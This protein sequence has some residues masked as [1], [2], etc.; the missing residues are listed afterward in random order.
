MEKF[1]LYIRENY[2]SLLGALSI[3]LLIWLA[4]NGGKEYSHVIEVPLN[5]DNM[6]KNIVFER[7]P[8]EKITVRVRA[9][10]RALFG[11]NFIDQKIGLELPHIVKDQTIILDEIKDRINFPAALGIEVEDVLN[12]E[13]LEIDVDAYAEK[14]VPVIVQD[15]IKTEPGYLLVDFYSMEDSIK[16][17]GPKS[18]IHKIESILTNRILENNIRFPFEKMTALSNPDADVITLEPAE[19]NVKFVIEKLV[20]RTIYNIP[21]KII[22][23]SGD[24]NAQAIPSAISLRIK[25]GEASVSQLTSNEILVLFNFESSYEKGRLQYPMQIKTPPG[26]SWVEASPQTFNLSLVRKDEG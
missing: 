7:K 24:I 8:P 14:Y 22:N 4:I 11:L 20:E 18:K 1:I 19:V 15:D 26:V 17:S 25:G 21:I 9:K 3:S 13:T 6:D 10:G 12:P 5:L 2:K 16:I 23:I